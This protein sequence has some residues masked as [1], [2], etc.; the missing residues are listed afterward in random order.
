MPVG[1]TLIS[2]FRSFATR[3]SLCAIPDNNCTTLLCPVAQTIDGGEGEI[4]AYDVTLLGVSL[5]WESRIVF[6][7]RESYLRPNLLH[8]RRFGWYNYFFFC[9]LGGVMGLP[10]LMP[11]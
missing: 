9:F 8:T 6:D 10:V 11:P 7:V 1:Q 3:N 4:A 2:E 5:A